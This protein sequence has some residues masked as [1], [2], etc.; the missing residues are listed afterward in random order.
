M[1]Y[2]LSYTHFWDILPWLF[3]IILYRLTYFYLCRRNMKKILVSG[4]I[5]YDMIMQFDGEFKDLILP[6][7]IDQL[8]VCFNIST[9]EKRNWWTAHNIAYSLWLLWLTANTLLLTSVGK[10]FVTDEWLEKLINYDSIYRD[11]TLYTASCTIVTEKKQNQIIT[12]YLWALAVTDPLSLDNC[13]DAH[14]ISYAML[15]PNGKIALK[16]IKECKE[17]GIKTFF[18]PWQTIWLY[19][20]EELDWVLHTVDYLI[21]NE[22]EYS[23]VKNIS[24]LWD[25]DI[26]A[27][28][29]KLIITLG[30]KWTNLISK[31][32]NI[33]VPA[34]K[35]E[36]IKDPTWAWDAFR[37]WL[38]YGLV[39]EYSRE[40][41]LRYWNAVA[42]FV[43]ESDWWMNHHFTLWDVEKRV[44]AL[45]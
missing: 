24:W 13:P 4:S 42:S 29:D 33:L 22:Y 28:V 8:N 17:R 45:V 1:Y 12:F 40:S 2:L 11:D 41:S 44:A 20:K 10:D 39:N 16:F 35:L 43:V 3:Y 31:T 34:V 30:S 18:D 14:E 27:L 9:M 38:L 6:D 23:L 15:S 25:E 21:V 7:Q 5:A 37:S 19:T 26:L 36:H 32:E